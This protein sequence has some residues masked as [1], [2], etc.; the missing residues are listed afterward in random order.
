[1]KKDKQQW[2]DSQYLNI[3]RIFTDNKIH[4]HL[5]PAAILSSEDYSDYYEFD[6]EC[7]YFHF[8]TPLSYNDF[9]RELPKYD[10]AVPI[11]ET[12]FKWDKPV[13]FDS[14]L[15]SKIFAYIESGLPILTNLK[16]IGDFVEKYKIGKLVPLDE[17]C[18]IGK[19]IR[20]LDVIELNKNLLSARENLNISNYIND[21]CGFICNVLQSG[22]LDVKNYAD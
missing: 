4:Y 5:Y 1:M 22:N 21:M 7:E 8:H 17:L 9:V 15:P 14:I 2:C 13:W 12:R 6:S 3:A 11:H 16:C 10:F 20:D 18:N 19:I